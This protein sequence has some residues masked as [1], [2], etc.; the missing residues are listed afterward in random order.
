MPIALSKSGEKG[1][2]KRI[3]GSE[4]VKKRLETLGL[5]VGSEVT[6]VSKMGD[7]LILNVKDSRLALSR[8]LARQ[9]FV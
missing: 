5:I 1:A 6:V 2:I 4:T 7:N 9:I 3:G 8:E